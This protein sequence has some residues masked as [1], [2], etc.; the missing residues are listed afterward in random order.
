MQRKFLW[1]LTFSELS[2]LINVTSKHDSNIYINIFRKDST[3]K[4][5]KVKLLF[6]VPKNSFFS[7]KV[8]II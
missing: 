6:F 2:K 7:L 4:A 1:L 5:H 3:R 8:I